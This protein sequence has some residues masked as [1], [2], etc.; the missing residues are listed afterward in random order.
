MKARV[1]ITPALLKRLLDGKTLKFKFPI[2]DYHEATAEVEVAIE[3]GMEAKFDRIFGK[4]WN[5]TLDKL[6]KLT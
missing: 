4:I 1:T 6:D 3:E 2:L 5:K